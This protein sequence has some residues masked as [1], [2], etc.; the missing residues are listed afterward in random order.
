[1]QLKNADVGV[2]PRFKLRVI[3]TRRIFSADGE[4]L[5][6]NNRERYFPTDALDEANEYH[7]SKRQGGGWEEVVTRC[8]KVVVK[9]ELLYNR[10][11][12]VKVAPLNSPTRRGIGAS[13]RTGYSEAVRLD[14]LKDLGYIPRTSD[15]R[16]RP[17]GSGQVEP[18]YVPLKRKRPGVAEEPPLASITARRTRSDKGVKR[19]QRRAS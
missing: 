2:N 6:T 14:A 5:V 11:L 8:D 15:N 19:G 4:L 7:Y 18:P 9:R 17:A 10:G 13:A 12:D 16:D 1:M 3:T